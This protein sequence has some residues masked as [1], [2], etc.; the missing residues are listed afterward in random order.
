MSVNVAARQLREPSFVDDVAAVLAETGWPAELLQLE[1][2][3]S[4]LMG[5]PDG[6]LAALHGSR[7]T[8]GCAS[9]STTSAPG[10]RTSPTCAG[11]R[12]TR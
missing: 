6:S 10:T 2:T 8:W 7:P 9:R 11:C 12:C 3:E 4:A 5:T 1:L